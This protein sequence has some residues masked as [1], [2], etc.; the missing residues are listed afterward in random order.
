MK[1]NKSS[2]QF[3]VPAIAVSFVAGLVVASIGWFLFMGF[4]HS[5][6]KPV[7]KRVRENKEATAFFYRT[8]QALFEG[9]YN[10]EDASIREH[11]LK[12]FKENTSN[13]G[14]KCYIKVYDNESG[15][16]GCIVFF[17][18]GDLFHL[19]IMPHTEKE[20]VITDFGGMDWDTLWS[21]ELTRTSIPKAVDKY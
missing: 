5:S 13:L 6:S 11:A 9:T 7:R 20:F 8:V 15:Y 10:S 21:S 1:M 12:G 18:S 14:N 17:P 2:F 3:R 19:T 16:H 4:L